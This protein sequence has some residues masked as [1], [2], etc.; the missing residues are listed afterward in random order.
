MQ[1]GGKEA[2]EKEGRKVGRKRRK[3]EGNTREGKQGKYG[4]NLFSLQDSTG[5]LFH[6]E[7]HASGV[8]ATPPSPQTHCFEIGHVSGHDFILLVDLCRS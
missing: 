1:K 4:A 8:E 6:P 5:C 7:S 3:N 2:N